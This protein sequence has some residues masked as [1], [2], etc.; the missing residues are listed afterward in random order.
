MTD[1]TPLAP[2]EERRIREAFEA[3]PFAH[4]LGI[5]L[6]ELRRGTATLRLMLR[7]EL[8]RNGGIAH[9]GVVA[10]LAD[11]AAAFALLTL[12]ERGQSSATVDLTIH[13]LRPLVQ[14]RVHATSRVIRAGR[15]I[16]S[17]SVE[18]FDESE[19]LVATALTSFIRLA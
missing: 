17:I 2:E 12:S 16:V 3:V 13:Y 6:G 10:S 5:E 18:V 9:G 1:A 7:D 15:R 8:L 19:T 4:F 14:G 11:T